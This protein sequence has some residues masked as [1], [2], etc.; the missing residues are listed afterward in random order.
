MEWLARVNWVDVIV[1]I[2]ILRSTYVGSQ[3]GLLGEFFHIFWIFIAIIFSTHL[4]FPISQFLNKY[5]FIAVNISDLISFLFV[6]GVIYLIFRFA[7]KFLQK[8]VKIEVF[9]N[10]NRIGGSILGLVKGLALTMI[11]TL[12]MLL[13]PIRYVYYSVHTKSLT[14]PFFIK[15]GTTVYRKCAEIVPV[16]KKRDLQPL[17]SGAKP[18]DLGIFR[19]KRRNDLDDI[20]Q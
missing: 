19:L 11:I 10:L 5:L 17:L 15:A 16:M 2:I 18:L 13:I 6:A 12:V 4:Y 8:T 14:G 3:R 20:L 7:G 9:P 1:I